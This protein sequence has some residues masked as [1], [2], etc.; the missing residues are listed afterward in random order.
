MRVQG[1]YLV[2]SLHFP[3]L[4]STFGTHS[5]DIQNWISIALLLKSEFRLQEITNE[6]SLDYKIIT[7]LMFFSN[8]VR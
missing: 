2:G 4:K 1:Q 6:L 8:S 7:S 3:F 5:G